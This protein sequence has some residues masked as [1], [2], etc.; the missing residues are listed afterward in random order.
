[1]IERVGVQISNNFIADVIANLQRVRLPFKSKGNEGDITTL[2]DS[3]ISEPSEAGIWQLAS[4]IFLS[5]KKLDEIARVEFFYHLNNQLDIDG[6]HAV[7]AALLYSTE[8][9]PANYKAMRE[10]TVSK[11]F[12]L[13]QRLNQIPGGTEQLVRMRSELL[14]NLK[15]HPELKRTDHDFQ[16]L[17]RSWFNRGFL[18][19]R[20][21][22]WD[23]PA[24]LL[25]KIIEYEAVHKIDDWEGLRQRLQP[26]DRRC[27]AFFHPSMPDEPLIFV[28]VALTKGIPG[29]IDD[30]LSH[31]R[32]TLDDEQIDTATFYSISNCQ[33]GLANVSFGNSLIKQVV[34][35]LSV[36]FPNIKTYA[37]LSPI[38]GFARWAVSLSEPVTN[39]TQKDLKSLAAHYLIQEKNKRGQPLDPVARFHLG[40]GAE[41]FRLHSQANSS[42]DAQASAFGMMVNYLYD[43]DKIPEN[44]IRYSNESYVRASKEVLSLCN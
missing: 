14:R 15:S 8:R 27:F 22:T 24:T 4:S 30:I 12:T 25:E 20:N 19:L 6:E 17:L 29:N 42:E 36:E 23:S 43:L 21:I 34:R 44:Q 40:N 11:R 1:M 39:L 16:Y 18:V 5:Y 9:T 10:H 35:N 41:V 28:E 37:T 2:C 13:F 31:T 32:A 33:P 3:L 38:P 7:S 26:H